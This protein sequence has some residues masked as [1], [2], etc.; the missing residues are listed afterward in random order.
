MFIQ[1]LQVIFIQCLDYNVSCILSATDFILLDKY[2]YTNIYPR[3]EFS[4]FPYLFL[5]SFIS[6][7]ISVSILRTTSEKKRNINR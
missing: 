7:L 1:Y 5:I 4:N 2:L 3:G 6:Y